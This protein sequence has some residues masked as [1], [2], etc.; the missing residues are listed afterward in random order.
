M[1]YA[2][3]VRKIVKV[4]KVV[5][6]YGFVLCLSLSLIYCFDNR[7]F[8]WQASL[9]WPQKPFNSEEFKEG[10]PSEQASMV[11]DIIKS[12]RFMGKELEEVR[13]QLGEP[14]G[15]YYTHD[16]NYTYRLSNK[17]RAWTLTFITGRYGV[18]RV[19]IRKNRS[20]S[21][22]ILIETFMILFYP[23]DMITDFFASDSE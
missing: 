6:L 22:Y 21:K 3:I 19:Y 10:T 5:V 8:L 7:L 18:E 9:L 15:E 11:V 17:R 23:V 4:V 20:I 16:T 1:K 2:Y 14:T 13:D 12:T